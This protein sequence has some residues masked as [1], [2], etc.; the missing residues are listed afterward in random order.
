MEDGAEFILQTG[1]LFKSLR[2]KTADLCPVTFFLTSIAPPAA[3]KCLPE[4]KPVTESMVEIYA[5]IDLPVVIRL[6]AYCLRQPV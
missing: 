6:P 5:G 2:Q 4:E 3:I 1:R